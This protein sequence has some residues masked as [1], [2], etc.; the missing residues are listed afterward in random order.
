MRL[1]T[2]RPG[3][4]HRN[5]SSRLH[6]VEHCSPRPEGCYSVA[7]LGG[8]E[9]DGGGDAMVC[10]GRGDREGD[11]EVVGM[12]PVLRGCPPPPSSP[13]WAS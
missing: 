8:R 6:V 3:L 11:R 5:R 9:G 12:S 2:T 7:R 13:L 1:T 10:R 4:K